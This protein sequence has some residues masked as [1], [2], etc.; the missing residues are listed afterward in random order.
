MHAGEPGGRQG[1]PRLAELNHDGGLCVRAV[2]R[3][4]ETKRRQVAALQKATDLP[5]D[6]MSWGLVEARKHSG[7]LQRDVV[8]E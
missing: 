5:D 4:R 2:D 8:D 7:H 3:Q 1:K 6:K